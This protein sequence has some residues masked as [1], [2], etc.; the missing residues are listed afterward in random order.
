V[1]LGLENRKKAIWAAVLGGLAILA[2]A[3]EI[4]P[5]FAGGGTSASLAS[6]PA[7][8]AASHA[9]SSGRKGSKGSK[10]AQ[11]AT[12]LDPTL[13][14]RLLEG[15]EKTMYSGSGRN[16][17]VSQ[18]EP[19]PTPM[20]T[21]ATDHP[22]IAPVVYTPPPV[23]QAPPIPLKF[24]GFA[25][26]PGEP[27]RIFLSAGEDVFIA[28]EGEIVDRRYKVVRISPTSVEMQDVVNSGPPQNIPLTQG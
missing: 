15:T 19:P 11:T 16:I 2:L 22:K 5:F 20:G 14:L 1:K 8:A 17:F 7:P 10:K 25:S 27:K 9:S 6:A 13:Q 24:F 18:A 12:N 4:I 26:Q 28:G 3:Y 23:Q 21:G